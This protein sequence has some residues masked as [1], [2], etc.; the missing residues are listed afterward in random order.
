MT[1]KKV[2][3]VRRPAPGLETKRALTL[4]PSVSVGAAYARDLMGLTDE[5]Y[6]EVEKAV[7]AEF[8]ETA[9]ADAAD[10]FWS[11]LAARLASK[12]S[13]KATPLATGFLTRVERNA[14]SNLERSLKSTSEDLTLNMKNTP[15]VNKA[16]KARI[17]DSVDLITRIPAEFLDKVKQDVNDSLR[18]GNG[19]A[20][21]QASMEEGY[22]EAK[23]HAQ[24]VALDQTRKAYTAVN[25]AKMRQN[26][27]TKFEWVHS[28]GSQE[29]RPYHLHTPAQGGL[30]GG[31]FDINDPP[32][33]NKKTGERGLP[34]DD[35]N[36]RCTMRPIVTFDDDDEAEE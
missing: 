36:C 32:V 7:L 28:G 24:L 22:G 19:L 4:K 12:F 33:I 15:A 27:I 9:A 31:I 30:N 14:T 3:L 21:L 1:K 34:G 6:K 20:D 8:R 29:P 11:R 17:S 16:I 10:D 26:G 18:K 5:M 25:T 2:R 23:R 35:Y 13:A